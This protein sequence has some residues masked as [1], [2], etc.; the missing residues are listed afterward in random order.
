MKWLVDNNVPRG[1]TELLLDLGHDAVEVRQALADD[2]PDSV[3]AAYAAAEGFVL[4]THDR[5]L[6]RRCL[7]AGIPHLWLR[8]P[9]PQDEHRI[10]E[11][12]PAI[13]DAFAQGS[14]RVVVSQRTLTAGP[15]ARSPR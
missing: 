6:A 8:T 3:V 1:V 14:V 9:E 5:G 4:V 11:A 2:A 12:L 7:L 13:E 10:R 15:D